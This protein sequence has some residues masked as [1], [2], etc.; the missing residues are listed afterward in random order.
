SSLA[1]AAQDVFWEKEGA[2]TGEVSA[3]MLADLG[4]QAVI[5][6]H[7]ERRRYFGETDDWVAR[8]AAAALDHGLTPII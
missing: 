7:S 6:G 5:V 8:K 2:Y 4:V 1:V 3:A